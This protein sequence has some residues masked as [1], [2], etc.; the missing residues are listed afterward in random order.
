MGENFWG[1]VDG[2]GDADPW[3]DVLGDALLAEVMR[4]RRKHERGERLTREEAELL[5]VEWDEDDDWNDE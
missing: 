4:I 1:D 5:G 2:D 3:D